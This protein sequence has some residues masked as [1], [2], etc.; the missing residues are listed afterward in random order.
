MLS[1]TLLGTGSPLPSASRAGPAT[2]V[3]GGGEH[4]LVDAGRGVLMRLAAAGLGAPNLTALLITHLHSDHITDLSDVITTRWVMSFER[5]PLTIVGPIGT[6][7]VVESV[8]DSLGPDIS[9]RMAHHDDLD[10]RPPVDVLE[11]DE[12]PLGLGGEVVLSCAPTDHRPVEPSIAFRFDFEGSA[13]VV[14]GDTVPC[15]GL[16]GLC[17]GADA[18]VHTVIRKDIIAGLPI[19][20]IVDTLDYHSSPQE[21]GAT[22]ERAGVGTLVL[23]HYVPEITEGGESEWR[24][25]AAEAFNGRIEL[26]DDLHR[27]EVA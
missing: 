9:Y 13:V 18:L 27:A 5:T 23:T 21:A 25:L 16:D 7:A 3:S 26:G 17:A 14:A 20:R 19:Q 10:H 22:A 6:A 1:I 2:L 8:L 11:L 24:E 12:G 15:E 4:Y